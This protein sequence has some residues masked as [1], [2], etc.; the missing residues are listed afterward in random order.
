MPKSEVCRRLLLLQPHD[1]AVSGR[2][3]GPVQV[4]EAID[5]D[6]NIRGELL[7]AELTR[8]FHIADRA[9][10]QVLHLRREAQI[11][12]VILFGL[13]AVAAVLSEFGGFGP[14][15]TNYWPANLLIPPA[16]GA[17]LFLLVPFVRHMAG[18]ED[19][20][21]TMSHMGRIML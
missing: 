17:I 7:N 19:K 10:A 14:L 11:F 15:P 9:F 18:R 2:V 16:V 3:H 13:G 1:P 5:D 12:I 21:I 4:F 6:Q 20:M 8:M